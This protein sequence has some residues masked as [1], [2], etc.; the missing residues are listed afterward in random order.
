[1]RSQRRPSRQVSYSGYTVIVIV[2]FIVVVNLFLKKKTPVI[3]DPCGGKKK[4]YKIHDETYTIFGVDRYFAAHR[5]RSG[6]VVAPGRVRRPFK[7]L[8]I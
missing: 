1:M 6:H 7:T 8:A 5:K 2:D 4:F 3:D